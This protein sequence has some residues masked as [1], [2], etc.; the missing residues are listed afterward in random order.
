MWTVL[1]AKN[2]SFAKQRLAGLLTPDE[3]RNL[4]RAMLEDVLAVLGGHPMIEGVILVSDDPEAKLLAT[5]Y[6]AEFLHESTLRATGLNG[7]IQAT[8][9][10]LARRDIHEVM[11]IHGDL[12]LVTT[13]E[14][15]RLITTHRNAKQPALT[16]APDRHRDGTNCLICTPATAVNYCYGK[17]SLTKHV[18]QA[19]HIGALVQLVVD[20]PGASFDI[21]WPDDVLTL[22]NH[23]AIGSGKRTIEYLANSGIAT[24][25]MDMP[26]ACEDAA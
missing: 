18:E 26:V 16:I 10:E 25:V 17:S 13:A 22:V 5:Q 15:T 6:D 9:E 7:V 8:V 19:E 21:D 20:L 1:P 12:P 14:I 4:F 2:F 11:V 3:R 24:R 23:P